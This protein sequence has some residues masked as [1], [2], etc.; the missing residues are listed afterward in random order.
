[1]KIKAIRAF[2]MRCIVGLL[3]LTT[4]RV[5]KSTYALDSIS[6]VP[7]VDLRRIAVADFHDNELKRDVPYYLAHFHRLANSVQLSGP[8]CGFIALP[9]WRRKQ[10]NFPYNARVLENYVTLAFFYCT[11]RTWNPYFGDPLVRR[12]LETLLDFWCRIQNDDG[13]FSEYGPQQWNLAATGFATMFMGGTLELLAT[14]PPIDRRLHDRVV[15]AHKKA[16]YAMLMDERLFDHGRSFSNQYSCLWGGMLAHLGLYPN[17]EFERLM[18][19][20]LNDSLREHQSPAGYWYE[21]DGC[22]WAYTHGTHHN[23]LARAWR[24]AYG[25]D[26]EE[27][28]VR[29]EIR[30]T[31]WLAYNA[32]CEPGGMGYVLNR[33][34]ETR[35]RINFSLRGNPIAEKVPLA[36]AFVPTETETRAALSDLRSQCEQNWPDV[37]PLR[38]YS[39]HPILSLPNRVWYPTEAQRQAAVN[40][41]PYIAKSRFNHQRSDDRFPQVYTFL[42]RPSYYAAF[43]AG[44]KLADQQRFGLGLLWTDRYGAVLQSQTGSHKAVWGTRVA[45]QEDVYETELPETLY[46]IGNNNVAPKPGV[47]DLKQGDITITYMLGNAGSKSVTFAE[48]H[49]KVVVELAD[50]FI[51]QLP[52]LRHPNAELRIEQGV[53]KLADPNPVLEISFGPDVKPQTEQLGTTVAGKRLVVLQLRAR[54]TLNYR[55]VFPMSTK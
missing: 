23:N 22:D 18:R 45:H 29:G 12:R 43:N 2:P 7:T 17:R 48:D 5:T 8:N 19:K 13:R 20:R 30:W 40:Q 1:M 16:I 35:R 54:S 15:A 47:R 25:T 42:R 52:L 6:E 39:P 53:A 14:G 28:L 51:E 4:V 33:G 24:H 55:L 50:A 41:L 11:N 31:D 21:N 9:V 10:D 46:R 26:L 37:A 3:I 44:K 38:S 27:P 32:V 36:R 49:I 34:I